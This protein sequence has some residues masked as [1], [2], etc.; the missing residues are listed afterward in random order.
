MCVSK[1]KVCSIVTSEFE[2]EAP[3]LGPRS[4]S[5]YGF[6][7]YVGFHGFQYSNHSRDLAPLTC[8]YFLGGS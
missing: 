2:F 5:M 8:S 4:Y 7:V 3:I 6:L 1:E